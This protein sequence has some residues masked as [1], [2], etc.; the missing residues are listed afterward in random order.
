MRV[1]AQGESFAG[2][3]S[4]CRTYVPWYGAVQ[5]HRITER[6]RTMRS[7]GPQ[8]ESADVERELIGR[9]CGG[10]QEAFY[11][12]VRP[13][14]RAVF[15]AARSVLENDADAE[16]AAQDAVLK[17]F[18]HIR[19]FRAESKFSTWLVQITINTALMKLRKEHRHLYRSLDEPRTNEEGDYW[20]SDFADWR[21]IPL[22]ALETK[23]L[24]MALRKALNAL[25]RIYR[26]VLVCR[27]VQQLNIAE[28]AKVLG[29]SEANVRTRLLRARLQMRDALA[30]G[31][32][33]S[34]TRSRGYEK[35][36]PW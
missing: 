25:S 6:P 33:G 32:D 21:E 12:L 23:E 29:I 31:F 30:P 20:P 27:D 26:E 3:K 14:E 18:T 15:F 1:A 17:A 10:D 24:R 7:Q 35:V 11:D 22:E 16:E 13:Y 36:R 5:R 4:V 2:V 8:P 9:V 19:D 28:T 34:W